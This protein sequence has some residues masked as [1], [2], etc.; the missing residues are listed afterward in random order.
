[1][2]GP[3]DPIDRQIVE[4][5]TADAR[6]SASEVGRLARLAP[7]AAKRRIDRLEAAGLICGYTAELDHRLVGEQIEAFIELRFAPGTQ[8]ADIDTS[9]AS[10]SEV[11]E[12]FTIAGDPD[13]LAHVRVR[14][15]EHLK[16]VVDR[17]RRGRLGE[18]RVLTTRTVVVLGRTPGPSPARHLGAE[19]PAPRISA[20][21]TRRWG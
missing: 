3:L 4:V 15:L 19:G 10:L 21:T 7:P 13:A 6:R 16:D 20:A 2:S 1:M 17:I 8:A 5:L 12:S 9:V 11:I 14:D 18:P